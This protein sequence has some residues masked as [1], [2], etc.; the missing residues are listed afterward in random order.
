MRDPQAL[1]KEA[2]RARFYAHLIRDEEAVN[3]LRQYAAELDAMAEAVTGEAAWPPQHPCG[4][5][6]DA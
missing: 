2:D 4:D 6:P 1:H 3:R 5:E